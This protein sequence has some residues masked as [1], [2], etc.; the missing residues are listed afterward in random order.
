MTLLDE[1]NWKQ[2]EDRQL[3][4]STAFLDAQTLPNK[5]LHLQSL[6]PLQELLPG[7]VLVTVHFLGP[8]GA[9][10]M[11]SCITYYTKCVFQGLTLLRH[12]RK[13]QEYRLLC[14][15]VKVR[16]QHNSVPQKVIFQER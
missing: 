11:L 7:T 15:T 12:A 10:S 5:G 16:S 14:S 8:T 1:I 3:V 6:S 9:K 13:H 2:Q 4:I